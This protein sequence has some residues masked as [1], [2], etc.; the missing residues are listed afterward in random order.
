[1]EKTALILLIGIVV[2]LII[3]TLLYCLGEIIQKL[4]N[5]EHLSQVV[6]YNKREEKKT[7]IS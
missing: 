6:S 5:I 7:S 2:T 3:G 4:Q 1:L